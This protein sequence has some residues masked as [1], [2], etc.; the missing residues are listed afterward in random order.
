MYLEFK[1]NPEIPTEPETRLCVLS[2]LVTPQPRTRHPRTTL[3]LTSYSHPCGPGPLFLRPFLQSSW[4]LIVAAAA[5]PCKS[6]ILCGVIKFYTNTKNEI[7]IF[8][9]QWLFWDHSPPP[10]P[11]NPATA[12]CPFL[13]FS[14][15]ASL[16]QLLL[17]LQQLCFELSPCRRI[18]QEGPRRSFWIY[19]D[20]RRSLQRIYEL[21]DK[22]KKYIFLGMCIEYI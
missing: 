5:A 21:K 3:S 17:L 4:L 20:L 13:F 19:P 15:L 7:K 6:A 18:R 1:R 10:P 8:L 11:P 22:R 2:V 16:I 12:C 9:L 14:L